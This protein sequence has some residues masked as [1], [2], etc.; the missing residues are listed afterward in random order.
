MNHKELTLYLSRYYNYKQ[1][2]FDDENKARYF[3][4]REYHNFYSLTDLVEALY[5]YS[6][7]IDKIIQVLKIYEMWEA[8]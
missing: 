4:A 5:D 3:T 8:N 7:D 6:N 1:D 2:M